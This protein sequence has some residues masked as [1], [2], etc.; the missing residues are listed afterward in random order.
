MAKQVKRFAGSASATMSQTCQNVQIY[1]NYGQPWYMDWQCTW[2]ARQT[3]TIYTVP[4]G[5]IAKV[6]VLDISSNSNPGNSAGFY[7]GNTTKGNFI[8]QGRSGA[9]SVLPYSY[10]STNT[11]PN[12]DWMYINI[13]GWGNA[14]IPR[15][16]YLSAGESI[17]V[18]GPVA[19]INGTLTI[20]YDFL[21]VE[22]Y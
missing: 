21:V 15:S 17:Y 13:S 9:A 20:T 8:G 14:T 1:D 10:Q 16:Y 11:D 4:S 7:I 5:R 19:G 3:T 12:G 18:L 22:E 6:K 2:N